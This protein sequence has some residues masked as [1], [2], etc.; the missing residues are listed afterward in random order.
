MSLLT[1]HHPN[2]T[3]SEFDGPFDAPLVLTGEFGPLVTQFMFYLQI[4]YF[5]LITVYFTNNSS[6]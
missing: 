3:E 2:W 6:V 5:L 1:S 4:I